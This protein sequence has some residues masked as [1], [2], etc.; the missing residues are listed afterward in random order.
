MEPSP[1]T[2]T[3]W[4]HMMKSCETSR[5]QVAQ[6]CHCLPSFLNHHS[7]LVLPLLSSSRRLLGRSPT[8]LFLPI[9]SLRNLL[10]RNLTILL[11]GTFKLHFIPVISTSIISI[12][13]RSP[14][15][16]IFQPPSPDTN[17]LVFYLI[18]ILNPS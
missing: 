4:N 17:L 15:L 3:R 14:A 18:P 1:S 8:H 6:T 12:L 7:P 11:L 16:H 2:E 13:L 10:F 5:K 9:S